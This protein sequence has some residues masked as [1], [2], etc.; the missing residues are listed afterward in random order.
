[1][2]KHRTITGF[3]AVALLAV[4]A[5][6]ATVKSHLPRTEGV[7]VSGADALPAKDFGDR[8]SPIFALPPAT[9]MAERAPDVR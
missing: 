7:V 1:M 6:A 4:T 2:T 3:V 8:W 9:A 5:T